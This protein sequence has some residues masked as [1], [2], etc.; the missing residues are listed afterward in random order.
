MADQNPIE[1]DLKAIIEDA[2]GEADIFSIGFTD[3]RDHADE[4]AISVSVSMRFAKD[5]PNARQQSG[6][7]HTL[8]EVLEK[9]GDLRFPYLYFD[10]LD[11]DQSPE[12]ADEFEPFPE[13]SERH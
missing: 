13:V 3:Y 10:A 5:I 7:T 9:R 1:R 11:M 4:P 12:D 2:L 6:L 8:R